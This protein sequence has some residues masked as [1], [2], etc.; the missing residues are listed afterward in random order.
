MRQLSR[1]FSS[2]IVVLFLSFA[3][4]ACGFH[5]RGQLPL[6]DAV[7]VIYIDADRTDYT[8]ELEKR[9]RGSGA[10]LVDNPSQAKAIL[11][12]KDEYAEREVL[13]L[14]TD[15]RATSYKLYYTV[16]YVLANNKQELLKEGRLE[17]QNQYSFDSG[18][19]VVQ[20]SQE[21]ELLEEMYEELALKL[22]RQIGAL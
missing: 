12:I 18:Q 4:T 8:R 7:S 3:V 22:V 9:L 17:E 11:Q 1:H 10:K 21:R 15:S 2:I 6:P 5:L 13:T 14:N 16:E 20:E 19:A